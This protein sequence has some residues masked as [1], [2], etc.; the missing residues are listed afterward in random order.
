MEN[1]DI[2]EPTWWWDVPEEEDPDNVVVEAQ[3][4]E[5]EDELVKR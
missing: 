5:T 2:E 1:C 3:E 4:K